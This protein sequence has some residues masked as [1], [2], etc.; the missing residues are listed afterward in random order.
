MNTAPEP[1]VSVVTPVYNGAKYLA[2]CIES[3]LTQTYSNFEYIIVNNCSTDGT[4]EIASRYAEQ[5]PRIRIVT[6]EHFVGVIENH[7]IAFRQ[8]SPESKYCKALAADD[9]LYPECIQKLVE[10]AERNPAVS[11]VQSYAVNDKGVRGIGL[12]PQK[13]V[14]EGRE[15][16]RL[17]LLGA[18]EAF[19]TPSAVLYRSTA[20]RERKPFTPAPCLMPTWPRAWIAWSPPI[21]PSSTRFCRFNGSTVKRSV[22]MFAPSMASL[23]TACSLFV[24]TGPPI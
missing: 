16:C 15:V 6:N 9:S 21:S 3:V 11:I 17:Y 8:I 12:P 24:N 10:I 2:E 20:V 7:N 14:F 5:D 19:G 1:L 23:Q 13:S 4:L 18:L 22:R